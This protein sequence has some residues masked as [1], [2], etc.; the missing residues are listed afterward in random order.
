ML[1][2]LYGEDESRLSQKTAEIK[3]KFLKNQSG[4]TPVVF[5]FEKN[6]ENEKISKLKE[7]LK[8]EG[9]F[10]SKQLII[11]KNLISNSSSEVQSDL[12]RFLKKDNE[13]IQG[14][15]KV[16]LFEE[17]GKINEKNIFFKFLCENS[18]KQEFERLGGAKLKNWISDK[19]KE[20]NPKLQI[21]PVALEKLIVFCQGETRVLENELKK[22]ASY[23]EAGLISEEDI[24]LLVKSHLNATI[25]ET[26]DAIS[27]NDKKTA[28]KNL[29]SRLQSGDDPHY[30]FSMLLYQ[31]RNLLKIGD[32]YFNG[33][34]DQYA[35]SKKAKIHPFVVQKAIKSL[36]SFSLIK[37]KEIYLEMENLDIKVKTGKISIELALDKFVVEI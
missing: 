23:R 37:L 20:L 7:S 9:L 11:I 25:F 29:H 2:F 36:R 15:E 14:R 32:F 30:I 21:S 27:G 10:T 6:S 17:R 28:L 35:I 13:I 1:I 18:K 8:K 5:E 19:L 31:F 24:D 16:I 26:I 4:A 3:E 12:E 33:T 34:S 22:L